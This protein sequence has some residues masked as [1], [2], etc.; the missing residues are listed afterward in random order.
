MTRSKK[1]I[2]RILCLTVFIVCI[3]LLL[4]S[5]ASIFLRISPSDILGKFAIIGHILTQKTAPPILLPA[6]IFRDYILYPIPE[7]V[8]N[9]RVDQPKKYSGYRYILRFNI[10]KSDL[11]RLI[12]SGPLKRVWN[13]KY[14]NGCLDWAWNTLNGHTLN[15]VTITVYDTKGSHEPEWFKLEQWDNPE[16]YAFVED[17]NGCSNTKILIYN[18]KKG[19][20]YF[21]VQSLR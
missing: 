19:E 2:F 20:A 11:G 14:K 13:V 16:A 21:I 9:I 10:K 17:V 18:E 7:S 12:D 6:E 15:G 8:T 1:T 4:I 3:V 5:L